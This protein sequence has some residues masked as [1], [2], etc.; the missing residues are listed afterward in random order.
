MNPATGVQPTPIR[1]NTLL[2]LSILIAL[3]LAIY[4]AGMFTPP[5]LDDAD[6]IH[7]EAA[8]EMLLRHDW[9][10][11][12][13][14][15]LRYLEK[16]PL[17]YWGL[18]A[19][20]ELLGISDWSTR[21]PL[22]LGV[23]ALVL[24]TYG[25]G[26][27]AFGE[28]GGFYSALALVT[29]IGPY[30][31]T[32]FLIPDVLVGL[33]LVVSYYFFLRSLEQ[34]TPSRFTCWGFAAACA[35]N[36]LT[37][38]LIGLVF[39][40]GT[41]GLYL[42]LTR[43]LRH[44]KKLR[45]VSSTVVFFVL[46][47]P[48]HVLAAIRNPAQGEARG[49]L[50]F[51]FVNEHVMRFLNKRVPPGYDTVPLV[52]FWALLLLWL[53]PWAVFLPQALRDVPLR[54]GR[55]F[56]S[57]IR[58]RANLLFFLWALVILLFFSFSTRQEYYTIP[59][60]P[61]MALLVGGW[62]ARE[63]ASDAV[64]ADRRAGRVSSLALMVTGILA[65][66]VGLALF[67]H[68]HPPPPGVDLAE[69]LKKNPQDYDFSLGHVLDF[70]PRALGLF[71]GPLLGASLSLLFGTTLNR[72]MR[73]RNRPDLGNAALS[74]M[75]VGLLTCVHVSFVRFS[76]ILSSHDLA[77]AIQKEYR[78][79]DVIVIDGEYHQ[80]S[81]LNFY[82]HVP[83]HVLHEPSGNLWYG[84][85]FPD[86]E[87]LHVFETQQSLAALWAGPA[88]VFLWTDHEDP[89]ELAGMPHFLLARSGGKAIFTNRE[90]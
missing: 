41:I 12:Y 35:L 11:L 37:K 19:S 7:A 53:I 33:W 18:A 77:V 76:P 72:W 63:S 6:S 32:R 5:L 52:L 36:V 26:R 90:P 67:S 86:A 85:K 80:A 23:L 34:E 66:A 1:R 4:V 16:A 75:M 57:S 88:R 3:W 39:P 73:R 49:F 9:V 40:I 60:L 59:A 58:A 70:T 89:K 14:N 56:P 82:T 46:A 71:C 48:W 31:F 83:V 54:L 47:A 74:L 13:T 62:L 64:E 45:I 50:W 25:L 24:A 21:L 30:I 87:P 22:M 27:Y 68:T 29:S 84:E 28:R 10:T 43:N 61:G 20:Y 15:G 8:R 81:T 38:G 65:A 69:L 44:L 42:L 78:P 79:G 51:Y 2:S 55:V 17:M